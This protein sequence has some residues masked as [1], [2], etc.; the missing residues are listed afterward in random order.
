MSFAAF[1]ERRNTNWTDALND[2]T[3][4]VSRGFTGHEMDDD[5]GLINMN[6]RMYDAKLGR[7]LQPD[8]YIQYPT[9]TQGFN[10]YTYVNNNPLSFTDPSG[11]FGINLD[12]ILEKTVDHVMPFMKQTDLGTIILHNDLY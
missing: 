5:V 10:R 9:S 4:S 12:G 6:A 1:G 11:N 7:F 3:S 8:T 2:I